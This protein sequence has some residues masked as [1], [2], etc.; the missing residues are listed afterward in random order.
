MELYKEKDKREEQDINKEIMDMSDKTH[1]FSM[2]FCL[3]GIYNP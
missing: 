2:K 3:G 1:R